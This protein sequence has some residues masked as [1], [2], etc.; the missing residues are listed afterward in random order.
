MED[1]EATL[2]ERLTDIGLDEKE[3]RVAL[4]EPLGEPDAQQF[5]EQRHLVLGQSP[6]RPF[7][8]D[9]MQ[10]LRRAFCHSH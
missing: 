3:A 9:V 4:V 8:S 7:S 10:G 6:E 2:S 5:R 1:G